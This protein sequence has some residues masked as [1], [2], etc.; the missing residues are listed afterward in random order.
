MAA[1]HQIIFEII[2]KDLYRIGSF[3]SEF[4]SL[5]LDQSRNPGMKKLVRKPEY[6]SRNKILQKREFGMANRHLIIAR[7]LNQLH[8]DTGPLILLT[9]DFISG[10]PL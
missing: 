1:I 6:L 5:Q 4:K 8:T 3:C 10:C 7:L 2:K 9:M